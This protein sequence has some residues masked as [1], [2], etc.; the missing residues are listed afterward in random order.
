MMKALMMMPLLFLH[1]RLN[2][3][4]TGVASLFRKKVN[5][6]LKEPGVTPNPK[7]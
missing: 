5:P 6:K 1:L 3:C 7:P 4:S 2:K